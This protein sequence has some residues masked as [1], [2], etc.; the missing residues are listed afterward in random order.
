M[1][2]YV[3]ILLMNIPQINPVDKHIYNNICIFFWI[4]MCTVYIREDIIPNPP[5]QSWETFLV[6]LIAYSNVDFGY[7]GECLLIGP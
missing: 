7:N 1:K 3:V 4:K 5:F 6:K 2:K